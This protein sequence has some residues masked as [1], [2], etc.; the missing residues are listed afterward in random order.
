MILVYV[1]RLL[2]SHVQGVRR[3]VVGPPASHSAAAAAAAAAVVDFNF[4][5]SSTVWVHQISGCEVKMSVE[6]LLHEVFYRPRGKYF[7][8]NVKRYSS[9]FSDSGGWLWTLQ[10]PSDGVCAPDELH[11]W[12]QLLCA[13]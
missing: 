5:A 13:R 2:R 7:L 6:H 9:R 3:S 12:C 10:L 4:F 11:E 1:S 8:K